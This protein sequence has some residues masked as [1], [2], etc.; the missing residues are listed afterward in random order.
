MEM[1][2]KEENVRTLND[3]KHKWDQKHVPSIPLSY[4]QSEFLVKNPKNTSK[5]EI[6]EKYKR[7]ARVKNGLSAVATMYITKSIDKMMPSVNYKESPAFKSSVD[8]KQ[9]IKANKMMKEDRINLKNLSTHKDI[10]KRISDKEDASFRLREFSKD[11]PNFKEKIEKLKKDNLEHYQNNFGKISIGVHGKELP[12]FQKHQK[13]WWTNTA[14]YNE[15][16]AYKS[17]I[18]MGEDKKFYKV[19]FYN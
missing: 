1:V 8:L 2:R 19:T 16:P 11:N 15:H 18:I 12:K 4:K 17:A 14:G 10:V 13:H 6:A 7:E 9:T 5:A 3:I